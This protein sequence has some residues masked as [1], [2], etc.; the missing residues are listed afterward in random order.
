L[1]GRTAAALGCLAVVSLAGCTSERRQDDN[2]PGG[3]F[4]LQV[5]DATFPRQQKLAQRSELVI[6]VRNADNKV[7]PNI[8]VSLD[9][10][11]KRVDNP[12][13]ADPNRPVFVLNGRPKEIGGFPES[14]EATPEAGETAYVN[15]WALGRLKPGQKK[16]FRWSFTA[17]KA[18]PYKLTY[19]VNAGLDGKAKA[20]DANGGVPHGA[21]AG[22]IS[23]KPPDAR[24][25]EDGQTV[26]SGTR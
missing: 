14:K 11:Y 5:L 1:V 13:L 4:R 10:F 8:G 20:E 25:A 23:D 17:V 26:V 18:G 15:T 6:K 16:T 19:A 9:G 12:D 22:T 2:E 21:F 3:T 7:V 24:V